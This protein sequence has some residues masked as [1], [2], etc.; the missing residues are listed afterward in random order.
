MLEPNMHMYLCESVKNIT[1]TFKLSDHWSYCSFL[2]QLS[3]F[4]CGTSSFNALCVG[5]VYFLDRRT[6]WCGNHVFPSLF[7]PS[8][9][10]SSFEKVC[11]CLS[12]NNFSM[13]IFTRLDFTFQENIVLVAKHAIHLHYCL[14]T[15]LN[16][17][18]FL[19]EREHWTVSVFNQNVQLQMRYYDKRENYCVQC[20]YSFIF[21][22]HYTK[23]GNYFSRSSQ[24]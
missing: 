9:K 19:G 2:C 4:L 6:M 12:I 16:Y 18:V 17:I 23:I 8:S 13:N 20:N 1:T 24:S 3:A 21:P 14:K 22:Y 11:F 5:V 7:N 15:W 10:K